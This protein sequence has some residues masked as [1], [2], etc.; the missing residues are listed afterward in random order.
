[1]KE[2]LAWFE[3]ALAI[4]QQ[5]KQSNVNKGLHLISIGGVAR[6]IPNLQLS[7]AKNELYN[8]ALN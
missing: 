4:W 7:R 6:Q 5:I 3:Q 2:S 1:M 8:K